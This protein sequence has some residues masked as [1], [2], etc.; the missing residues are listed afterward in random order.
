M[1]QTAEFTCERDS[2]LMRLTINRPGS[3][4][5]INDVVARGLVEGLAEAM[6]DDAISAVVLSGAG[7]RV[8]CAG[9]D[10]KNPQIGRAHV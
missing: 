8:F 9:R 1:S 2:G 6:S 7:N 5:A 4:N 10:L 3:A